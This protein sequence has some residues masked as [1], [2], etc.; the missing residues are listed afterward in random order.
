MK[1]VPGSPAT[2][3]ILMDACQ[4]GEKLSQKVSCKCKNRK[5]ME[6]FQNMNK[7]KQ[8]CLKILSWGFSYTVCNT[9]MHDN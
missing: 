8:I 5:A 4:L 2:K 7:C 1:F 6:M 9:E 3:G